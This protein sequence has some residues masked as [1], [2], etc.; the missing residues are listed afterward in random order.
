[1]A[2]S[3]AQK[4]GMIFYC[5]LSKV[6]ALACEKPHELTYFLVISYPF[7]CKKVVI[8]TM[9]VFGLMGLTLF[10]MLLFLIPV[11]LFILS[12]YSSIISFHY[13]SSVF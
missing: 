11:I 8:G 4:L 2:N 7:V 3:F 5:L 1:M 13:L 12:F 10:V 6:Q 9:L